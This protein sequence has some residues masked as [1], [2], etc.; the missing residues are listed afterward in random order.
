MYADKPACGLQNV[1]IAECIELLKK[2]QFLDGEYSCS[3]FDIID[4]DVDKQTQLL[5]LFH[6]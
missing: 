1:I 6:A 5:L 4:V 2:D 3:D